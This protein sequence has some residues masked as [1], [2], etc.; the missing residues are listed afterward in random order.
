AALGL[1]AYAI[2]Q[3]EPVVIIELRRLH[4]GLGTVWQCDGLYGHANEIVPMDVGKEVCRRLRQRGV[5]TISQSYA[6][7]VPED[8]VMKHMRVEQMLYLALASG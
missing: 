8:L 4:D 1:T 5:V 2:W 7:D 3:H 6:P